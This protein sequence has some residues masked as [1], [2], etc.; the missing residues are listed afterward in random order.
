MDALGAGEVSRSPSR[1]ISR[2]SELLVGSPPSIAIIRGE[3]IGDVLMTTPTITALVN[4]FPGASIT[5]VTN[6]TYLDGAIPLI[7]QGNPNIVKIIDRS[8][9][10]QEDYDLS[11]NLF[12]PCFSY[13]KRENPPVNRIDL[14]ARHCGLELTDRIPKYYITQAEI[15]EGYEVVKSI[16]HE[17]LLLVQTG[18]SEPMR[19]L[20]HG[21]LKQV[22]VKLWEK[23]RV[24]SLVI[25]HSSDFKSDTLWSNIPGGMVIKNKTIR[26]IAGI[27]VHCNLVLCPDSS[28]LH[29]AGALSIPTVALFGPTDPRARVNHYKN[30]VAIWG[31]EDLACRNCWYEECKMKGACW[32]NITVER[33]VEK[34]CSMLK[35]S[36]RI[37]S[38]KLIEGH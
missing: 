36:C 27:M 14:F 22:L 24:H 12:C 35:N 6:T 13:E 20:D 2:L 28:I 4:K 3:G 25:S 11:I 10:N 30:A 34:C 18:G 21:K 33:T 37:D 23:E 19:S 15:D 29:L 8:L 7:L 31:A 26:E 5:Y 17:R 38:S 32:A 16:Y 9:F 1:R